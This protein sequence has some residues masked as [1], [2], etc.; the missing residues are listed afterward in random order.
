MAHDLILRKQDLVEN[1]TAR[2]PVCLVLDCSP[3]MS[4]GTRNGSFDQQTDP[5]PID[6]LN[7]GVKLFYN[8]LKEDEVARYS[9]EVAVIAFSD[10]VETVLDFGSIERVDPPTVELEMEIGGTSIGKAVGQAVTLLDQRKAEYKEAGVDYFQPW[11]VL[12]TD[13][14]PTDDTHIDIAKDVSQRV[15]G[16][17]LTI[18][19]IGIG[20]GADMDVLGMFSPNR[21]PLRLSGLKF[22]EFFE[23]LRKSVSVTSQS[24]P[25]EVIPLNS[26][27]IKG[28][29][30]L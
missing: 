5:R 30:E 20:E 11:I 26:E 17:K 3:S 13:G 14:Q 10:V 8:A 21:K 19:P 2:V 23:W 12:M 29:A 7:E 1:P 6:E 18:F 16:K 22:K 9:A 4:E 28:W 24:T 27:G 25:G 15:Q